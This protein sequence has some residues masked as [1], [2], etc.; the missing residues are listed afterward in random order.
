MLSTASPLAADLN[1]CIRTS[2]SV[3]GWPVHMAI[4]VSDEL[5]ASEYLRDLGADVDG[6]S[7]FN[8]PDT[9]RVTGSGWALIIRILL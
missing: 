4:P 5:L 6:D 3:H 8:G 2:K 9:L 1:S 7:E